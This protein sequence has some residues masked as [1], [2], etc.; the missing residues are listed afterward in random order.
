MAKFH[1]R[2]IRPT[3]N[4]NRNSLVYP[5]VLAALVLFL[6]G[7]RAEAQ[8]GPK[9]EVVAAG[10]PEEARA[11]VELALS[12]PEDL[13]EKEPPDELLL[14]L[15]QWE[16]PQKVREALEPFG[17]YHSRVE[18]AVERQEDRVLLKV[19]IDPGSPVRV[20][21]VKVEVRGPGAQEE[22]LRE[23]VHSFPLKEG[24]VLRQDRYEEGKKDLQEAAQEAGYLEAEYSEKV[25]NLSLA[26]RTASITLTLETGPRY[27]FGEATFVPPLTYPETFLRRY[28]AFRPGRPFSARRLARTQINFNNSDRFSEIAIEAPREEAQDFR[29]PVRIRLTPTQP[30]R[31]RFGA[32]YETDNGFGLLVRYRDL[33]FN[34]WGHEA[35]AELRVSERLQGL[36]FDYILPGTQNLDNKVILKLGYKK[37]I[38]DSY[39]TRSI[40]TT[41]EYVRRVGRG[42]L[43]SGYL[44]FLQEDFTVAGQDGIATLLIPGA[45]FWQR[46]YDDPVRPTRGYRYNIE[47]RGGAPL[48]GSDG[49]FLQLIPQGDAMVPLGNGFSLLLRAQ[50]GVTLQNESLQSL[51]PSL[52]FFT[53]G[54]NSLRGYSYQS[55]GPKDA[56]GKVVGGKNLLAGT[57]E[58]EKAFSPVWGLAAFYDGGNAFDDFGQIEWKQDAG[59]GL[60]IYT[61]V[62]PVRIDLARQ[63][64]ETD[65]QFRVSLSIGFAL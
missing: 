34:R 12:L 26:E 51:P 31:F 33:N 61:P 42:R 9:I 29:V 49:F 5:L 60:R 22:R 13:L 44:Q 62:G 2:G 25:I 16:I 27:Y 6:P 46:R 11:N 32:G 1:L 14:E 45:R 17:Y 57:L 15:F 55:L 30:K 36:A 41:G 53:G 28:L 40:F 58:L 54:D 21:S 20:V 64:G 65:N 4:I 3:L 63:F 52:R 47:A 18:T 39:D 35:E 8:V 23:A 43:L 59:L 24:A 19:R 7:S 50:A 56:S 48:L 10:L 37:E 38:T